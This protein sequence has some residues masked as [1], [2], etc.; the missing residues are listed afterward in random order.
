[1]TT[2]RD[3]ILDLIAVHDLARDHYDGTRRTL[4]NVMWEALKAHNPQSGEA[5]LVILP[6]DRD[7]REAIPA[8]KLDLGWVTDPGYFGSLDIDEG[9]RPESDVIPLERVAEAPNDKEAAQ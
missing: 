9:C 7:V 3:E 1:M 5:W 2:S 6:W 4:E 8:I